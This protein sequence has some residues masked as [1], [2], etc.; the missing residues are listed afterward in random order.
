MGKKEIFSDTVL[1]LIK[2]FTLENIE[3][4]KEAN[5]KAI[6]GKL[7]GSDKNLK[8]KIPELLIEIES[9]IKKYSGLSKDEFKELHKKYTAHIKVSKKKKRT[10]LPELKKINRPYGFRFPPSPSGPLHIGHTLPLLLNSEYAKKYNGKMVLRIE[11]TDPSNISLDAYKQIQ[12]D[13]KWISNINFSETIIQSE[14]ITDYQK[15][16]EELIS[17]GHAYVCRCKSGEWKEYIEK[18]SDCPCRN[19]S[20]KEQ[21]KRWHGMLTTYKEGTAVLRIKT[22]MKHNNPAIRDWPAFRISEEIH[23]LQG[24]KY[25]VWPLMNFSVAIDDHKSE[26]THIIRGKDHL[27]NAERQKY[28]YK[29]FNWWIPEYIHIGRIN[30]EGIKVSASEFSDGIKKGK[31]TGVDDPKLPTISAFRRRGLSPEAFINYIHELGPSKVDKTV[32]YEEFMKA[33]Y[34]YNRKIIEPKANRYFIIEDPVEIEILGLPDIK[35]ELPLHP[36]FPERGTRKFKKSHKFYVEKIDNPLKGKPCR[37]MHLCNFLDGKFISK[38]PDS[39]LKA[40]TIHWLPSS[41]EPVKVKVKMPHGKDIEAIGE[42]F[43][44]N[45]KEGDIVQFER[46]FFARYDGINNNIYIFYQTHR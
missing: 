12:E 45:L 19:L 4:Y 20:I 11:D 27:T 23:P 22:D 6:L 10:G 30:F 42:H 44:S 28:I 26:L 7:L 41:E 40:K 3:K 24:K 1:N 21:E 36:D 25:R 16:A 5:P 46:K 8:T 17:M 9:T 35:S 38:D 31:Y 34:A 37:L 14:H 13:A 43:L 32:S 18:K 39:N 2:G 15:Y 33:I 29:Y